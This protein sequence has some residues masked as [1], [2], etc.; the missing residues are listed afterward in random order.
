M[1]RRRGGGGFWEAAA[2][3]TDD[4]GLGI[5]DFALEVGRNTVEFRSMIMANAGPM[6][7]GRAA[8]SAE[9]RGFLLARD[10]VAKFRA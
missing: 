1:R 7:L 2:E 8:R 9:H 5:L 4:G 10:E 3:A 6:T